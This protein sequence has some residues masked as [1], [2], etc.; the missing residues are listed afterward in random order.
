[1]TRSTNQTQFS[2]VSYRTPPNGLAG[3]NSHEVA[4][5]ARSA[6]LRMATGGTVTVVEVPTVTLTV[7]L[8][9]GTGPWYPTVPETETLL[10]LVYSLTNAVVV[11]GWEKRSR[12][13]FRGT[14]LDP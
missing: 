9:F 8:T 14:S 4:A 13:P 12:I 2:D 11:A 1:M 5:D 10:L 3:R 7:T 6:P